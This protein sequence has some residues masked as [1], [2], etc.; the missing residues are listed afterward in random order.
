MERAYDGLS[1]QMTLSQG[2]SLPPLIVLTFL[3]S[4]FFGATGSFWCA[5]CLF[6]KPNS[7]F[8]HIIDIL[9]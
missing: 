3:N 7:G 1:W 6:L 9:F 8:D 4:P 5:N 2:G